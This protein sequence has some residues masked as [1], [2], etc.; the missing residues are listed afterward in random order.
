MFRMEIPFL[1]L[2]Y[3]ITYLSIVIRNSPAN[4]IVFL[5]IGDNS[6][7]TFLKIYA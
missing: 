6:T 1:K 4:F 5:N 3:L 2:V 7:Y